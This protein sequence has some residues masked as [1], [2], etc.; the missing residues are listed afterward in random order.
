MAASAACSSSTD[1]FIAP[2]FRLEW[3]VTVSSLASKG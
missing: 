1:S 3:T 2:T